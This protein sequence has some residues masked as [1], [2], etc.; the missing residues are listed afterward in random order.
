MSSTWPELNH[1]LTGALVAVLSGGAEPALTRP[2]AVPMLARNG[3]SLAAS[4]DRYLVRSA[5]LPAIHAGRLVTPA[6][7]PLGVN[8]A[9]TIMSGRS[10]PAIRVEN[11]V[12]MS[13]LGVMVSFRS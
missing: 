2:A 8:R 11:F 4:P 9:G 1:C 13:A 5:H 3:Y 12:G 10:S 7:R 6:G